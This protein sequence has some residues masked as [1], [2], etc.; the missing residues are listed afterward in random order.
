MER[1]AFSRTSQISTRLET[2]RY[3]MISAY[4]TDLVAS[5]VRPAANPF[6]DFELPVLRS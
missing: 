2:V 4:I 5:R 3:A 1:R 6:V